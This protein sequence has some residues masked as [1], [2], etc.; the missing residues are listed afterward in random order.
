M[1]LQTKENDKKKLTKK[2]AQTKKLQAT[3]MKNVRL[4]RKVESL[5]DV[6]EQLKRRNVV[7][8]ECAEIWRIHMLVC[9]KRSKKKKNLEA[10]SFELRFFALTLEN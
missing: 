5:A 8:D 10:Y 2:S 1:S 4:K 6:V 3:R 7:S 9:Q